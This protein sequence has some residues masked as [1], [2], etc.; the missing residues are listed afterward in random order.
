[1]WRVLLVLAGRRLCNN[2]TDPAGHPGKKFESVADKVVI[3]IVRRP[4]GLA[5]KRDDLA[6]RLCADHNLSR[7]LLPLGGR[8]RP[9]PYRRIC[10]RIRPGQNSTHKRGKFTS[11]STLCV[12]PGAAAGSLPACSK[13]RT[14]RAQDCDAVPAAVARG[15]PSFDPLTV[16]R[17]G[18][19]LPFPAGR[20]P[21]GRQAVLR[22]KLAGSR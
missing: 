4:D 8:A 11:C 5:R 6:R 22:C 16:L 19:A 3:Y 10:R 1:M 7:D 14:G 20:R 9:A 15:T 17:S 21:G 2:S 13:S 18:V 12:G